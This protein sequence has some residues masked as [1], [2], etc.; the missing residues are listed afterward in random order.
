MNDVA[1]LT[2]ELT[3]LVASV[4]PDPLELFIHRFWINIYSE[5]LAVMDN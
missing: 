5:R 1:L 3:E 4:N 2:A